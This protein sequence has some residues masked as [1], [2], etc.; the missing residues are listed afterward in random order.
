MEVFAAAKGNAE[1]M[2]SK[3]MQEKVT[4]NAALQSE[5]IRAESKLERLAAIIEPHRFYTNGAE[6]LAVPA[7]RQVQPA[8]GI[9]R[10]VVIDEWPVSKALIAGV[11][12]ARD[13]ASKCCGSYSMICMRVL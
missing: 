10:V 9:G 8:P 1:P 5:E 7:R 4:A 3:P 2:L 13:S 11:V 6:H 12:P